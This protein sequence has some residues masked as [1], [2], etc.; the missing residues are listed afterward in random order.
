MSGN[1]L[2]SMN[3]Y[4]LILFL[5]LKLTWNCTWPVSF[6]VLDVQ[7]GTALET[8]MFKPE[9]TAKSQT[10]PWL[11]WWGWL[12]L[13]SC[14]ENDLCSQGE[15]ASQQLQGEVC[16]NPHKGKHSGRFGD[17]PKNT[18]Q[19][20]HFSFCS[21]WSLS[22]QRWLPMIRGKQ[23][24]NNFPSSYPE[25]EEKEEPKKPLWGL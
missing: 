13:C 10:A 4:L 6:Q 16:R 20:S 8:C 21:L 7:S 18:E 2:N 14:T 3:L 24:G 5:N 22:S 9:S 12:P 23:T 11:N 15:L 17:W 25:A 19:R 1:L